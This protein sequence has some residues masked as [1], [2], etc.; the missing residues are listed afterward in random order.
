MTL[1]AG[2]LLDVN[3]GVIAVCEGAGGIGRRAGSQGTASA[4][5]AEIPLSWSLSPPQERQDRLEKEHQ[6]NAPASLASLLE[7]AL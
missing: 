6:S 1:A 7:H 3:E 5:G 4:Q 2:I